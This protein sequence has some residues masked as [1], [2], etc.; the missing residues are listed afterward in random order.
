MDGSANEGELIARSQN[1]DHA[2]FETLVRMHQRMIHA[3]TY[4]MTGSR[5]DAAD[6]AQ[7]TFVRA[8]MELGNFR[9]EARFSTWLS[10]IA[11]NLCL[12]WRKREA[13]RQ[14]VYQRWAT[15]LEFTNPGCEENP[16]PDDLGQR[17]QAALN[18]LPPKQRAAIVLTVYQEMSHA[19]A[20]RVLGCPEATVAWRVF[21]ARRKLRRMLKNLNR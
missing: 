19:D 12:N 18:W 13:R 15:A 14:N 21:A 5:D 3:L 11:I 20:A 8:Y 10:R 1:G 7:E 9:G 4:R 2:A 6:L 16:M 17:V